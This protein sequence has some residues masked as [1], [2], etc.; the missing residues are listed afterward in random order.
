MPIE[1]VAARVRVQA[2]REPE[3]AGTVEQGPSKSNEQAAPLIR[4]VRKHPDM[5]KRLESLAA[6]A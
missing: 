5:S 6:S 4:P 1:N 3:D 2:R